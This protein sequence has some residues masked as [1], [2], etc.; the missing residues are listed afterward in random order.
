[1]RTL[2]LFG[3]LLILVIIAI[4][5]PDQTAWEAARDL[6]SIVNMTM[7]E[8][9][10]RPEVQAVTG[11][12]RTDV[13]DL[14]SGAGE[15]MDDNSSPSQSSA[16]ALDTGEP[17]K[18]KDFDPTALADRLSETASYER[19]EGPQ[20]STDF[21]ARLPRTDVVDLPD[22]PAMPLTPVE[23][24]EIEN[25]AVPLPIRAN[26]DSEQGMDYQD[27]KAF[28]EKASRLLAEIE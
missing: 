12:I 28:Y 5:K 16:M 22:L 7:S 11:R 2:F 24:T 19:I 18:F 4:K 1:M 15:E 17:G 26:P 14:I 20:P 21:A 6:G 27:I 23:V 8:L 9:G 13:E 10:E 25:D 3:I